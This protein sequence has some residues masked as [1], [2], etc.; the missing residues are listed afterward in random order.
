MTQEEWIDQDQAPPNAA[1]AE[2]VTPVVELLGRA[3]ERWAVLSPDDLSAKEADALALLVAAELVERRC[4]LRLQMFHRPM[5]IEATIT[6]TG[7]YG[8][9]EALESLAAGL[10][11]DWRAAFSTW[12][13]GDARGPA[14]VHCEL[15]EPQEWRLTASG[16]Q[17]RYDL[18]EGH[19]RSVCDFVLRR[20]PLTLRPPVRGQ[21]RLVKFGPVDAMSAPA[22]IA[23]A[24]WSEGAAA[25]AEAFARLAESLPSKGQAPSAASSVPTSTTASRCAGRNLDTEAR[26]KRF[27]SDRVGR[28]EQ[29]VEAV[30]LGEAEARRDFQDQFG[31]TAFARHVVQETG[32]NDEEFQRIKTAVQQSPTYKNRLKP[33]L[34]G[35]PPQDWRSPEHSDVGVSDKEVD[36]FVNTMRRQARGA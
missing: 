30:L 20:W 25:F 24:N 29:L 11:E 35:R 27:L 31:P 33:V 6:A 3:P 1:Q 2:L 7:E 9:V 10:W 13:N 8:L 32:G 26:L 15:L 23:V 16:V 4:H 18:A 17:A 12:R 14:P 28:Y 34:S 5:V 19:G 22:A 36:D 21:G